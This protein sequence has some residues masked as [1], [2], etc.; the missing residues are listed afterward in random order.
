MQPYTKALANLN[1]VQGSTENASSPKKSEFHSNF[2]WPS[3]IIN[4]E[5]SSLETISGL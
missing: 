2:F 4:F 5:V 1:V 3:F